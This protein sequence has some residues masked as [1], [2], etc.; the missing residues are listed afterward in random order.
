VDENSLVGDG[1]S[2][3]TSR[4]FDNRHNVIEERV[5]ETG[6]VHL[7]QCQTFV[8]DKNDDITMRID[9]NVIYVQGEGKTKMANTQNTQNDKDIVVYRFQYL[10]FDKHH[11]WLKKVEYM[12][13]IIDKITTR[14]IEYYP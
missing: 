9:S 3:K 12:D 4:K 2:S 6:P 10:S 11:N 8:Y 1:Y 7:N 13:G 14:K 5:V